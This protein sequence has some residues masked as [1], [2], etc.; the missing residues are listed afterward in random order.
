MTAVVT[1]PRRPGSTRR[2]SLRLER[3]LL[4][5]GR[6]L[7]AGMDEVGRGALAGPVSVG[8]VTVDAGTRS[9]PVGLKDSKLLPPEERVR[10]SPRLRRWCREWAVGHAE[11]AEVDRYGI[12]AALRLAGTRALAQLALL[13]DLVLLDGNHDWLTPPPQSLFDELD[14]PVFGRPPA[15][16]PEL[17]GPLPPVRTLIKGDLR[18]TAVAAASVLAKTTRD[19]IM[20]ELA[21]QDDRWCWDSNKG[22]SAPAHLA[23]LRQWGPSALHRR[24]WHL[25]DTASVAGPTV[26]VAQE[27]VMQETVPVVKEETR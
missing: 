21:A 27:P 26:S 6:T 15:P 18:C 12:I 22:Y 5:E 20:V 2:P 25:P 13:P 4:R 14:V 3:S 8:V 9:A 10:L 11:A 24:T 16:L 23:A 19:A 17:T 1:R 7:V